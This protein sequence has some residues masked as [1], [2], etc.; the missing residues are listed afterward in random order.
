MRTFKASLRTLISGL[1]HSETGQ[2]LA[3]LAVVTP[4]LLIMLAGIVSLGMSYT[5]W[6]GVSGAANQGAIYG[7]LS[8]TASG[9]S[10]TI[11]SRALAAGNLAGCDNVQ[12]QS[13]VDFDS[14]GER[15]VTVNVS[16]DARLLMPLPNYG[17]HIHLTSHAVRKVRS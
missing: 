3:E 16:C 2:S 8:A 11:S 4:I 5:L 6:M 17:N 9:D 7:S 1:A 15:R 10:A 12:V 14:L 13:A